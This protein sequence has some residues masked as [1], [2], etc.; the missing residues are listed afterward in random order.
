MKVYAQHVDEQVYEVSWKKD[1]PILGGAIAGWIGTRYLVNN[2]DKA[3]ADEVFEL[4]RN[5]VWSFDR[6]AT[7]NFS[8]TAASIS[9][10]FLFSSLALP[11]TL[12]VSHGVNEQGVALGV[13][14]VETVFITD[15]INNLLKLLLS[16]TDRDPTMD[17]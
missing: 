15:T 11:F 12:Y 8:A 2:A 17:Y 10:V 13:M 16:D 6:G 7:D 3:T 1:A 5:N 4:D 9:D 14:L